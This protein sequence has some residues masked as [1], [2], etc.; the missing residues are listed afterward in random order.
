MK[1]VVVNYRAYEGNETYLGNAEVTLP[2]LSR[3]TQEVQG[4]GIN[5]KINIPVAGHFDEMTM[6]ISFKAPSKEQAVLFEGRVHTL[7][8][9]AAVQGR[10]DTTG[11]I[12][13]TAHK[14]IV[15]VIPTKNALGKLAP[16]STSDGSNEYSVVYYAEYIEGTKINEIDL[17]NFICIING[18]D[19]LTKVRRALG[20]Y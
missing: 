4:A 7:S 11:E 9:H 10:D 3:I 12:T 19:E 6:T 1:N 15:K 16:A 13:Q 18:N 2:D 5:G 8:L 20:M 14:Y 17:N